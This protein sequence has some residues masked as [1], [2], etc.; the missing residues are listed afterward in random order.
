[1]IR[2]SG[3]AEVLAALR[4]ADAEGM[5]AAVLAGQAEA[6]A[7]AVRETLGT[8][9]GGDHGQPWVQT[10]ALQGSIGYEVEGLQAVVGSSDPAAAPQELGTVHSPPRPFLALAAAEAAS[11]IASAV[12][13]AVVERLRPS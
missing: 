11:G 5:M 1:M 13:T 10:G 12:G 9:P 8:P 2:V 4:D 7:S 6:L 3:L